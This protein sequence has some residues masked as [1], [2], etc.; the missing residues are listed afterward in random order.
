M[1]LFSFFFSPGL[2]PFEGYSREALHDTA[3]SQYFGVYA[4]E[5]ATLDV[6]DKASGSRN[7]R[8]D[9]GICC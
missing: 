4:E 6:L 1:V 3:S 8:Y 2:C 9:T 7:F 5:A